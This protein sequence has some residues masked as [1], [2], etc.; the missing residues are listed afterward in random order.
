MVFNDTFLTVPY[1]NAGT[2]P[3]YWH[4]LLKYSSKKATDE[5]FNLAK[6]WTNMVAKM[7]DQFPMPTAAGHITDPFVIVSKGQSTT[8]P[9]GISTSSSQTPLASAV[10]TPPNWGMQAS[11]GGNK[12]ALATVP[13]NAAASLSSKSWQLSS[14]DNAASISRDD[15]GVGMTLA[16]WQP[17]TPQLLIIC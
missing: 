15:F 9:M 7:P 1:M 13:S 14:Q 12:C 8:N 4:D 17:Q 16:H 11:E 3:P 2:E 5:E 10:L 6:D